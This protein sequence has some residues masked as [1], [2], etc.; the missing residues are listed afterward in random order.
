M[1]NESRRKVAIVVPMHNR[2]ELTCDEQISFAHLTHY[3]KPYDKYLVVPESLD[4][5]LPG[6]ALKRF[7]NEYF[8]SVAANTQ[9]LLSEAFYA[10]FRDYQYILIYHLD[11]LV[12]SDQLLPWCEMGLDYIGPPWIHCAD[13]PWVKESRVG[14]GGLSLR[15]IDSFLKVFR[16]EVRWIEPEEYWQERFA[17]M[18]AHLRML[19]LPRK[20]LKRLT[21]LN[22][23]R[24]EM[25]QW[26]LRPDGTKNEDH[27]WSDRARHYVPEFKVAS[28]EVGPRFAFEVAPRLCFD[29]NHSQL[30][31]GCHAWPRYDRAFWEPHLLR[32]QAA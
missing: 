32:Y 28:V 4:I 25:A 23:A 27:F 15:R 24:R 29:M 5:S 10:S 12:F 14:N 9:L 7:K 6:C 22:N 26:H 11:A 17:G 2:K 20:F 19:N 31:F 21:C 1:L 3:L 30:P 18:P 16:S 8:G 13:S